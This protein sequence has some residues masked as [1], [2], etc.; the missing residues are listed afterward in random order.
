MSQAALPGTNKSCRSQSA[1]PSLK[2]RY[3]RWYLPLVA[4]VGLGFGAYNYYTEAQSR[5]RIAMIEEEKRLA[6]NRELM[7]AYGSKE[8]LHDVQQALESYQ[9]R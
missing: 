6:R 3:A 8:S 9:V 4:A 2:P 7:D 1:S 5:R